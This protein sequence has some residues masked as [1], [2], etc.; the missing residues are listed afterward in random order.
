MP[1]EN[2]ISIYYK[3]KMCGHC[4]PKKGYWQVQKTCQNWGGINLLPSERCGSNF[5]SV[6][7][8]YE[9]MFRIT[10]ISISSK[11]ALRCVPQN[12]FDD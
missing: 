12:T 2:T 10:F 7:Y 9:H 8:D 6:I 1:H 11:I 4:Q 5:K 3:R